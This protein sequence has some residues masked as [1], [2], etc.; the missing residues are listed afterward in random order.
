MLKFT[1]YTGIVVPLDV[2]NIDTDIIIPKQFL[3]GI[4]K[5]GL[6][7]YLFHDWRY[8]DSNQLKK[9]NQ[10]ILNNKIYQNS[11]ILLT[12]ENFG[13]GSS[14]EHAVWSLLDYGFRVIIASSF[15]DIFYNNSFNNKLLLVTLKEDIIEYLFDIVKNNVGISFFVSLVDSK[16]IVNQNS[17]SFKLDNF[18]RSCLLNNLDDIDL[19]MRFLNKIEKYESKILPFLLNRKKFSSKFL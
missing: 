8:L 6:G 19:T 7:K 14:R 15:S 10:F 2:S 5:T 16:I 4:N 9:N 13:C 1:E 3:Q 17:F 11:S 12:R 18:R